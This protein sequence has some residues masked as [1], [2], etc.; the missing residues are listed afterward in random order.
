MHPWAWLAALCQMFLTAAALAQNDAGAGSTYF[1]NHCYSCHH[2]PGGSA[3]ALTGRLSLVT[4]SG[5]SS[6]I[7]AAI[8]QP[9]SDPS[10]GAM[11]TANADST[12]LGNLAAYFRTTVP[13][14][15]IAVST[16]YYN[17]DPVISGYPQAVTQSPALSLKATCSTTGAVPFSIAAGQSSAVVNGLLAGE[18]CSI[19]EEADPAGGALSWGYR[20]G[21]K[22]E[23]TFSQNQPFTLGAGATNSIAVNNA[24]HGPTAAVLHL[25]AGF[26]NNTPAHAS[27]TTPIA[28]VVH[29][30]QRSADIQSS[31]AANASFD[32][33]NLAQGDSCTVTGSIG[34]GATQ[35]SGGYTFGVFS[36][37]PSQTVSL[38][39]AT[40]PLTLTNTLITPSASVQISL[41][42]SNNTPNH[43]TTAPSLGVQLVCSLSGTVNANLATGAAATVN[44]LLAG[45]TCMASE[46]S[47]GGE[48]LSANYTLSHTPTFSPSN[49]LTLVA[50]SGNSLTVTHAVIAPGAAQF[51]MQDPLTFAAEVGGS[52]TKAT[53][54][55]NTAL[56]GS[57]FLHLTGLAFTDP[58]YSFA[59]GNGCTSTTELQP[60]KQ[61]CS[62][63]ITFTPA[64][65]A[66]QPNMPEQRYGT[67]IV[68]YDA[69]GSPAT[70]HLNGIANPAPSPSIQISDAMPAI[71]DTYLGST[72]TLQ[73]I[74]VTNG[75]SATAALLITGLTLSDVAAADYALAA[76]TG[77]CAVDSSLAKGDSCTITI[78]FTPSQLGTRSAKLTIANNMPASLPN[79]TPVVT[80]AGKGIAVP[81]PLLS[82][83]S[84]T[85][86]H[87][88][89]R[90]VGGSYQP[91]LLTIA[92]TGTAAL[93]I[94]A[95]QVTGA[96]FSTTDSCAPSIAAG[97]QCQLRIQYRPTTAGQADS[98]SVTITSN[99]AGS[100]L[101]VALDGSGV[102]YTAP[103]FVW[104]AA[105]LDFGNVSAGSPSAPQTLTIQNMGPGDAT[106]TLVNV[107]GVDAVNFVL[108]LQG[109][110]LN[111]TVVQGASCTVSVQFVPTA[112]GSR[113]A[114]LQWSSSGSAPTPVVLQ[115]TGLAG[116]A[117]QLALSS[118]ALDFG[119]VRVGAASLPQE[120]VLQSQGSSLLHVTAITVSTPYQLLSKDCAEP[121]FDLAPGLQCKL[122]LGYAPAAA[123]TAS[124]TVHI[125]SNSAQMVPD[126]AL[127]GLGQPPAEVSGGGC[128]LASGRTVFDPMLL[129]LALAAAGVLLLRQWRSRR[130]A[131]AGAAN[132]R[133]Q[134]P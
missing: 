18:S 32:V 118:G 53:T 44:N 4:S 23:A 52:D 21:N 110:Q 56:A 122:V 70:L 80:L 15:S 29:C 61:P 91:Q 57:A 82:I 84:P 88:G 6:A 95:V 34:A 100:P 114:T 27:P 47:I 33:G 115:G 17:N 1:S 10:G 63:V 75:P 38:N 3:V 101:V 58:Q 109:C 8:G 130:G 73:P 127:S 43:V 99:A 92:N 132:R 107:T 108:N 116:V 55:S 49:N 76:G 40:I 39:S 111:Q 98:G 105:S 124:G 2:Q 128:S 67:L 9:P 45:E 131:G 126:V 69:A 89:N 87:F 68:T 78:Q 35:P 123:G 37:T 46:T 81:A 119:S 133:E 103:V 102:T 93:L 117:A 48:A 7:T 72:T 28:F 31:F 134:R 12:V 79:A 5:L 120:L 16:G 50:G 42:Y 77:A 96:G 54:I 13:S 41:A 51:L 129:L 90:T 85:P 14:A 24:I 66:P 22:G 94:S 59:P 11:G 60:V 30:T 97:A 19:S 64:A 125:A 83:V 112:S 121:P 106:L 104:S 25:T 65:P 20:F 62:L 74:T 26:A 36:Y 71:A 86:I 113:R